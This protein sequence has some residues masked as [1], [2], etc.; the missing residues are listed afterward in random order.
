MT[1]GLVYQ[2]E[3]GAIGVVTLENCQAIETV[4]M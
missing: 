3:T 4:M 1:G 2:K